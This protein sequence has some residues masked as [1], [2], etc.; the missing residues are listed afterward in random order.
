MLEISFN[1]P[2]CGWM[3]IGFKDGA[4]EFHTTTAHSPHETALPDLMRILTALSEPNTEQDDFLLKWN[5]DPEEFDFHFVRSGDDLTIEIY[6][7]PTDER[8]AA[9]REL[10]YSHTGPL[11]D[12]IAAFAETFNQLYEDRDTDEFEFN[13]RQPFPFKEFEEFQAKATA[14]T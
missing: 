3:S 1:S 5:R 6:Q 13:W 8:D 7:Y 10:V 11:R 12:A 4:N 2:Q 9:E 14:V